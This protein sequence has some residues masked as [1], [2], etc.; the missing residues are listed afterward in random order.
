MPNHKEKFGQ[1]IYCKLK[2]DPFLFKG[3][4]GSI[5]EATGCFLCFGYIY[6]LFLGLFT[7]AYKTIKCV[8]LMTCVFISVTL[9]SELSLCC[10]RGF[11]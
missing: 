11:L 6:F 3:F 2:L 8:H 10:G 5:F 7:K 1:N 9:A 4:N